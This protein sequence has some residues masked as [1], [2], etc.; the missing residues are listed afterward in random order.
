M[1]YAHV[2]ELTAGETPLAHAPLA[3]MASILAERAKEFGDNLV[4]MFS[5]G[6]KR[7]VATVAALMLLSTTLPMSGFAQMA[8]VPA[9]RD[10]DVAATPIAE[11]TSYSPTPT[12]VPCQATGFYTK[13]HSMLWGRSV[14]VFDQTCT[15]RALLQASGG[16]GEIIL[17]DGAGQHTAIYSPQTNR[18]RAIPANDILAS[19]TVINTPHTGD[20]LTPKEP[21]YPLVQSVRTALE[22]A[23]L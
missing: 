8:H 2:R 11:P 10:A 9:T 23:P 22:A 16:Y 19:F 14:E 1:S 20:V 3:L 6:R 5:T 17:L 13:S 12:A 15:R 21:H 4:G 18:V 7:Q